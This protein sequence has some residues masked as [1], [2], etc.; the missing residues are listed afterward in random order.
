MKKIISLFLALVMCLS[1]CAC[2]G[3]GGSSHQSETDTDVAAVN[4]VIDMIDN[5]EVSLASGNAI[6]S[7]EEAYANLTTEQKNSVNNYQSLL[8]ARSSYDRIL[9]VFTLIEAIGP[10]NKNSESAIITAETAYE[11]LSI[12]ER[13]AITNANVLTAARTSYN[14]IPTEV[15][16]TIQN[17]GDYFTIEH[18]STTSKKDI[19]GYYGR[20]ITGSV[21]AKQRVTLAGMENVTI[22]VRVN[23]SVGKPVNGSIDAQQTYTTYSYDM[24]ISVSATSGSGSATYKTDGHYTSEYW[25]PTIDVTSVEVIA[26]T[27]TITID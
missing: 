23:C 3:N 16:L 8:N 15:T 9:N 14:A 7:A 20:A 18:T 12:E 4:N 24:T 25:Y 10:V 5:L 11:S 2:G 26:V 1:L 6:S 13:I 21:V 22:S 27:G 17:I 19:Y